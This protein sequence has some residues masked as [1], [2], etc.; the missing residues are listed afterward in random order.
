MNTLHQ[1]DPNL[2]HN[3]HD[4]LSRFDLPDDIGKD[5]YLLRKSM[6]QIEEFTDFDEHQ[7]L[8]VNFINE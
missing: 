3:V 1:L 7:T 6:L 8:H 4:L 2:D 5:S